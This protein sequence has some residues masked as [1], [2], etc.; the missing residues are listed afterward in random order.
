MTYINSDGSVTERPKSLGTRVSGF[1]W[2]VVNLIGLFFSTFF[3]ATPPSSS[4]RN[5]IGSNR[6]SGQS[7]SENSRPLGRGSNIRQ[8]PRNTCNTG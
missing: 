8:L 1:L 3:N 6:S 4:T 2:S 5:P 7:T